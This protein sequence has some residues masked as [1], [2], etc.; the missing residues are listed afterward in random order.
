MYKWIAMVTTDERRL[1][2]LVRLLGFIPRSVCL[3]FLCLLSRLVYLCARSQREHIQQN[4][5]EL[6]PRLTGPER[7]RYSREYF[8]NLFVILYEILI[9]SHRL[10][11][12]AEWRFRTVGEEV[13]A[14]TLKKGKGAIL[15]APHIGNFFYYYWY[16]SKRYPCLTVVTAQSKE[17]RPFYLLFQQLGCRGLDY[18][19]T[20]PLQ[21]MRQ[22]RKHLENNGVVFLLG[23]F[24][25]P[26]FPESV[27][28]QRRTR[29]PGGT[30]ILALEHKTPVI[31][32]YGY[33]ERGFQHTLVFRSPLYL[34]V[35]Y[36]KDQR[37]EATNALNLELEKMVSEVPGQWFYWFNVDER[38]EKEEPFAS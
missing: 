38:W 7:E 28:F 5:G 36:R 11:Q 8:E 37:T 15:F 34:D 17:I 33:R 18:D 3:F 12:T 29:S 16:L 26:Q 4:M 32:F 24:W 19:E 13:L 14:E 6:L 20:P 22:L 1:K 21:M 9:D 10:E 35:E 27:L 23:D 2:W 30:A 31:P 25:R